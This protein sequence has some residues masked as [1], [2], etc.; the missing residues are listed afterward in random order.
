MT[1]TAFEFT[2]TIPGDSRLVSAI[3]QLTAHAAEY[4]QLPT[5]AGVQLA[6][7][8]EH[9]TQAAISAARQNGPIEYR[10]SATPEALVVV[11]WCDGA[12]PVPPPPSLS[13]D[14]V[15]VDWT[16]EGSRRVCRIRQSLTV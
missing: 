8:V 1:P 9:A 12:V 7:H 16:L 15:S 5:E 11:F 10:F 2:V 13:T 14:Q 6:Q 3:R 4:A